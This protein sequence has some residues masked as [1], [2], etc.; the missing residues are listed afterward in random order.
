MLLPILR[1]RFINTGRRNIIHQNLL[2]SEE[3][4]VNPNICPESS[5]D[6]N[7]AQF[8]MGEKELRKVKQDPGT[9]YGSRILIT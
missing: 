7:V 3:N 9:R 8:V 1:S 4:P 2:E 6:P 5:S